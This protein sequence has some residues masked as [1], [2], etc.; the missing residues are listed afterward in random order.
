MYESRS[1]FRVV[2]LPTVAFS[3]SSDSDENGNDEDD[4]EE[5]LTEEPIKYY[6]DYNYDFLGE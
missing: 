6:V 3:L 5:V 1:G 4:E 2:E